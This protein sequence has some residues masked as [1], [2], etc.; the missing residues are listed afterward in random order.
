MVW[1]NNM[2]V[3]VDIMVNIVV[4]IMV[5]IVVN[6]WCMVDVSIMVSI[7]MVA[8]ISMWVEVWILMMDSVVLDV[9]VWV[10]EIVV[11]LHPFI[12]V[13]ELMLIIIKGVVV[14]LSF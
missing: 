1:S 11:I 9:R 5:S 12:S 2:S 4:I 8:L 10:V 14:L 3:V 13:D 6:S 7:N